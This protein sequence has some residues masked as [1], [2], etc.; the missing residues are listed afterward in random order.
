MKI[1]STEVLAWYIENYTQLYCQSIMGKERIS[2]I[3]SNSFNSLHGL[4]SA[5]FSLSSGQ[6]LTLQDTAAML[7]AFCVLN[8]PRVFRIQGFY[9]A[10]S[11]VCNTLSPVLHIDA[12]FLP[13]VSSAVTPKDYYCLSLSYSLSHYSILFFSYHLSASEITHFSS[14]SAQIECECL[15][16]RILSVL[17]SFQKSTCHQQVFNVY[18]LTDILLFFFLSTSLMN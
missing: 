13:G 6:T 4:I 15:E 1:K 2:K 8:T 17:F 18:L 16:D 11:S 10:L 5:Y 14:T 7:V 12:S 9:C 3:K